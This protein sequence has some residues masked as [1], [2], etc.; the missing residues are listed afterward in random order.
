M[1]EPGLGPSPLE[2]LVESV[3]TGAWA[4]LRAGLESAQDDDPGRRR[5]EEVA[6][7]LAGNAD[8]LPDPP[9]SE[10][11]AASTGVPAA[12]LPEPPGPPPDEFTLTFASV[13]DQ[14]STDDRV[15]RQLGG[16]PAT[17]AG[18]VGAGT[19]RGFWLACL[20]LDAQLAA[21][22]RGVGRDAANL[23]NSGG[24]PTWVELPADAETPVRTLLPPAPA[25][26]VTGIM[27]RPGAPADPALGDVAAVP[28]AGFL[29]QRILVMLAVDR[30]L[31]HALESLQVSGIH[32]LDDA[33][34][35]TEFRRELGRRLRDATRPGA[36]SLERLQGLYQLDEAV[37]S[38]VHQP[39]AHPES[40]WGDL[41]TASRRLLRQAAQEAGKD[42]VAAEVR[43]LELL[44]YADL[45]RYTADRNV[46]YR[47]PRD[48]VG[49]VL[50]CLRTWMEAGGQAYLGRVVWGS[51]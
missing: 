3:L 38:A 48:Q 42:G 44:P 18:P 22:W 49:M 12:A 37:C 30:E 25:L 10:S 28:E 19:W 5:A 13:L 43:P 8:G 1:A 29:V 20:R 11:A 46:A 35:A 4:A 9:A 39:P 36:G 51:E 47:V 7:W 17:C 31:C 15:R 27:V 21:H 41:A 32:R 14:F 6:A 26:G 23:A 34:T 16:M 33:A 2:L 45:R 40:W 24:E 50:A